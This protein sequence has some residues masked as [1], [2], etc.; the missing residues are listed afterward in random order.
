MKIRVGFGV[1]V[2][3]LK[4]GTPFILG[5]IEIQHTKGAIGHS[6]A[7]VLLHA[8][9]DAILGA[10]NLRDIGYHFPD[11]D[12]EYEGVDS[13]ELL[14]KTISLANEKGYSIGNIDCNSKCSA[15]ISV[16]DITIT[17]SNICSAIC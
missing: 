8:I 4:E 7:D 16:S 6:D 11:T 15:S 17:N 14:Q 10:A 3:K 9:C 13:K 1:D 12:K 2:H 5:G